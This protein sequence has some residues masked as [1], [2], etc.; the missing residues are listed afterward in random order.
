MNNEILQRIARTTTRRQ[1]LKGLG[2]GALGLASTKFLTVARANTPAPVPLN[3]SDINILNYLLN[4]EYLTAQFYTRATTGQNIQSQGVAV[5]GRDTM[6]SVTIKANPQV[7]FVTSAIEQYANQIAADERSHVQLIRGL[8]GNRAIAQPNMNLEGSF[9]TMAVDAGFISSGATFDPFGDELSFLLGAYFFE[10]VTVTAYR[11]MITSIS[12]DTALSEIAGLLGTE[13]YHSGNVRTKVF[14]YNTTA[15]SISGLI[16][17]LR[18]NLDGT[19]NDDQGV[20]AD[21]GSANIFLTNGSGIVFQRTMRQV[22][23]IFYLQT[24]ASKGGFF[25]SGINM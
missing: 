8:L 1:A 7:P 13:G 4:L 10:D 22:L 6:G 17:D 2:L 23:D 24:N 9:T 16:S 18:E 14:E 3:T 20:V 5:T 25:P 11:G 12:N 21:D 15:Q 19:G